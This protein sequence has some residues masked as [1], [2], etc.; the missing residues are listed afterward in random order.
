M[1]LRAV[2]CEHPV[3]AFAGCSPS[4][5]ATFRVGSRAYF[6]RQDTPWLLGRAADK[7]A[8]GVGVGHCVGVVDVEDQG[9]VER[10]GAGEH[11]RALTGHT[12]AGRGWRSARTG[13][14][15]PPA[16]TTRR[17]EC[18]TNLT[19]PVTARSQVFGNATGTKVRPLSDCSD[20]KTAS[21]GRSLGSLHLTKARPDPAGGQSLPEA[22]AVSRALIAWNGSWNEWPRNSRAISASSVVRRV[23]CAGRA[24]AA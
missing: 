6:K 9:K 19:P 1:P 17:R 16:V 2:P 5:T 14:C 24:C 13:V 20:R 23:V 15:S 8:G 10:I 21:M 18:G 4:V 22:A 11:L 7:V 3:A 12:A